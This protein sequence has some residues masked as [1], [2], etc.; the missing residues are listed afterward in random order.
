MKEAEYNVFIVEDNQFYGRLLE[1]T[2]S[3]NPAFKVS[4]YNNGKSLLKALTHKPDIICLDY[5]LPD[6]QADELIKKIKKDNISCE[7]VIVSGQN[8]VQKA[9]DLFKS[10]IYDYIVKDE[11]TAL[12]LFQTISNICS[13]LSLKKEIAEIKKEAEQVHE[14]SLIGFI[15]NSKQMQH[16]FKLIEKAS[17][18]KI[19]VSI[20]GETGTGKELVAK[21]IFNKSSLNN[22]KFIACNISAIPSEL[23]E[24]E[25]FGHEKGAFTGASER[26]T[27][28]FEQANEG[29]LFLDEIAELP[30]NI[31]AKLLRVLQEREFTRIG[32]N[33]IIKTDIRLITATHKNLKELVKDGKFREDLYYR[34]QGFEIELPPLRERT[35]DIS[36]LCDF[37]IESFCIEN[38]IKKKH[39]TNEALNKLKGYDFPG[40]VRELKSLIELAII[41]SENEFITETDIKLS[42]GFDHSSKELTLKEITE[43]IILERL[44]NNLGDVLKTA[45]ELQIGKSTIY[46]LISKVKDNGHE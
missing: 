31:Q 34:I 19:N 7:I 23:I 32:G 42:K 14:N 37:F 30:L 22:K 44:E 24:S 8:D 28:V 18:L 17:A 16:V 6:A 41:Y 35:K 43:K 46:N 4:I 15:G 1:H 11:N 21:S 3:K 45:R 40:N 27:G 25:L 29:T 20:Y 38:K 13:K 5:Y 36:S 9:I 26:R 39:L 10:G 2:L 12:K 33:S